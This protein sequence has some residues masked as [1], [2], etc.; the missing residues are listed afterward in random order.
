MR[1][2]CKPVGSAFAGSNPA[3]TIFPSVE[4]PVL[5]DQRVEVCLHRSWIAA[6]VAQA[7]VAVRTHSQHRH[8]PTTSEL[9]GYRFIDPSN[10]RTARKRAE[11]DDRITAAPLELHDQVAD[12]ARV[13]LR[14]AEDEQRVAPEVGEL[15]QR[16][17]IAA[18]GVRRAAYAAAAGP[19]PGP[20]RR[21]RPPP[22]T[23]D[24]SGRAPRRLPPRGARA[25][26]LMHTPRQL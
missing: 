1:A 2:F 16:P 8:P 3:P 25:D 11:A 13:P 19:A 18:R 23:S 21:R 17:R 24:T 9:S 6:V 10:P 20:D 5:A 22:A 14:A 7:D 12:P 4:V 26:V 15:V